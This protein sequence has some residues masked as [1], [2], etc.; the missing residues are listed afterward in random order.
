MKKGKIPP[1]YTA[2]GVCVAGWGGGEAL[3]EKD[4]AKRNRE[5]QEGGRGAAKRTEP[6]RG[7]WVF[8]E[9]SWGSVLRM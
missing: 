3:I 7:G 5:F 6:R 2:Q 8:S 9:G 1:D 4:W